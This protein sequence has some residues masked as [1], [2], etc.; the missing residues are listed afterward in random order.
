MKLLKNISA[1]NITRTALLFIS[2]AM[3]IGLSSV[4]FAAE[5]PLKL[6]FLN[7]AAKG[8]SDSHTT[9][10]GFL[11]KSDD[12]TTTSQDEV[13]SY[14]KKELGLEEKDF[15]SSSLRADNAANFRTIMRELDLE[16]ILILDVF[17]KGRKL[18]LV[19][20]GPDGSE[21][22][23]VRR[24]VTR[25][26]I[27][28]D[29]AKGVLK[30]TFGKLVPNVVEFRDAG[31][32]D[33]VA[34]EPEQEEESLSLLPGGDDEEEEEVEEAGSDEELSLK[35]KAIKN[36][37]GKY[38]AL[39]PG[40]KLQLGLLAGKRDLTMQSDSGF[41]LTHSSP[42]VGF[43]GRIDFIITKLSDDSALGATLLG[44]YAPFTTIFDE[45][46]T[47][48]SQYA[49]LGLEMR[50]LKAFTPE[51]F[52]NVFGGG[53]AM[54]ITID[55]NQ[56]YTG[57]RYIMARAGAGIMYQVGPV[58]LEV[59]GAILPVFSVNNSANAFGEV[60]GLSLGFEPMAGLSFDVT[61]DLSAGLR[62]SGQIFSVTHPEPEEPGQS[63]LDEA[64]S[65]GDI[66]HTGLITIGYGL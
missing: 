7:A 32:W 64:V 50:Y 40:L 54:S 3:L 8:G 23:D 25:G 58:L 20:I 39:E 63:V 2:V 37:S 11:K 43:G 56:F 26:R 42:F 60:G 49:R 4:A 66:I 21:I 15:R 10:N 14:A 29:D 28:K 36:R 30:E 52:V 47:F 33:A 55:Q 9:I 13:W 45:S 22:A 17:S 38:S 57:H 19:A 18:Q 59:A 35:E 61:D 62:Y 51:F 5:D 16:A 27:S 53:E 24:D 46:L 6:T 44:G 65:S 1:R 31:G 34:E 12:I 48:P 41:E